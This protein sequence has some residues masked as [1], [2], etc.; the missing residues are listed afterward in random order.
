[1]FPESVPWPLIESRVYWILLCASFIGTACWESRSAKRQLCTPLRSRC[2]NHALIT[3]LC[4]IISTGLFRASPVMVAI[5][6]A[7]SRT[8]LL[9]KP[10]MPLALR[11]MLT[12][13]ALD[14]VKYGVHRAC[15]II[16]LL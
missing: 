3:M 8:G 13:L 14:L 15:H 9:N 12:I 1:M 11:W 5:A 4:G 7:G 6:V 10:W 2:G 16:P